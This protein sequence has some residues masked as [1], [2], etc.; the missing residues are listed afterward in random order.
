MQLFSADAT[1]FK[2]KYFFDLEKF[3]K[4]SSKAAHNS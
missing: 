1:I 2:K 3:K 4:Q